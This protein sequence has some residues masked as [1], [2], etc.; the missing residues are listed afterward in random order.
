MRNLPRRIF[1]A[2]E[3]I[4][5]YKFDIPVIHFLKDHYRKNKKFGKKDR[6]EIS[7][8]IFCFLRM[9]HLKTDLSFETLCLLGYG[10]SNDASQEE[11]DHILART[12]VSVDAGNTWASI[13]SKF[14][15]DVYQ[16]IIPDYSPDNGL[17]P[18]PWVQS[19]FSEK[20]TFIRVTRNGDGIKKE[21]EEHLISY[22]VINENCL[23]LSS[24]Q[25][26]TELKTYTGGD[27]YVQ[28]YSSQSAMDFFPEKI[29]GLWW[30]ACAASG[31]K[32][33]LMLEKNPGLRINASD[34]RESTLANYRSRLKKHGYR[35]NT[36]VLDL[37]KPETIRYKKPFDGIVVD[38]PCTGS[39]TWA[40]S[41][42]QIHLFNKNKIKEFTI[43]QKS[44]VGE[45]QKHLKPGGKLVYITCSVFDEENTGITSHICDTFGF[46]VDKQE[47]IDTTTYG[48]DYLFAAQLTKGR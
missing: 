7:T 9:G 10:L 28:D 46:T 19:L 13:E 26:L 41:P 5:S 33:L 44:I 18:A 37:L 17:L 43:L 36:Q 39:G 16:K 21:L 32:S 29:R 30:D 4:A 3:I 27:F 1:Q 15:K 12:G 35:P 2:E 22:S 31:G 34:I 25:K 45:V 48:G 24:D 38:A 8:I 11:K 47:L 20:S 14:G 23:Q 6:K 42:E 40:R